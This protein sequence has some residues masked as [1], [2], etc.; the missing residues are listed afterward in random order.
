MSCNENDV[1]IDR[2]YL[3]LTLIAQSKSKINRHSLATMCLALWVPLGLRC[4]PP[5]TRSLQF[6]FPL[7][8]LTSA[9]R[10]ICDSQKRGAG[11]RP[12]VY[13][14]NKQLRTR[15]HPSLGCPCHI[16][17]GSEPITLKRHTMSVTHVVLFQFKADAS[18]E[19][20]KEVRIYGREVDFSSSRLTLFHFPGVRPLSRAE[21]QLHP[22]N[23]QDSLHPIFE[24]RTGRLSRGTASMDLI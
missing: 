8:V 21:N 2:F 5:L 22:P 13:S 23:Y 12:S 10:S 16:D 19:E 7:V 20:V 9:A 17:T 3:Q 15:N 1:A 14:L 6:P 18:P 11:S 4:V 24:G